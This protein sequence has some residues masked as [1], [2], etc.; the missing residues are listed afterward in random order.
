[1]K[2]K[3]TLG[4]IATVIASTLLFSV[5]VYAEKKEETKA[6]TQ[7]AFIQDLKTGARI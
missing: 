3:F 2:Q 7:E 4:L 1:M 5:P 6:A